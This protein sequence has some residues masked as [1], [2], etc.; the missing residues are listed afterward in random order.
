M[1]LGSGG[2]NR[3]RT[4]ILQVLVNLLDFGMSLEAA[5]EASRIHLENARLSIEAGFDPA[6]DLGALRARYPD[7]RLWTERSLFFGGV[8]AVGSGVAGFRGAGDPRRGGVVR[9][10]RL[11]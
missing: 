6:V 3:I 4:A 1:A 11:D 2:S 10:A 5:V 8:H 9:Q 7:H